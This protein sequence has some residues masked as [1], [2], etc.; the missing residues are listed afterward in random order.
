MKMKKIIWSAVAFFLLT[1][2]VNAQTIEDALRFT[3]S[4]G[5]ISPRA[6]GLGV[7]FHGI[8]DDVAALAYNPAGLS[9]IGKT[10]LSF[11]FGFT[12]FST[13]TNFL[14]QTTP[15]NSNDEYITHFGFAVPFD[16]KQGNGAVGLAYFLENNF[17]NN[18]KY[19]A[20]NPF[21][22][23]TNYY[24]VFGTRIRENNLAYEL[25]LTDTNLNSPITDSLQQKAFLQESGGLHNIVGGV[26][27][28]LSEYVSLGVALQGKWGTYN[29]KRNYSERDIYN[30]YNYFDDVYWTNIDFNRLEVDERIEQK[31]TGISGSIGIQARFED[32]LRF[33]A[34]IRFPTFYEVED[35]SDIYA[36]SYFD[37]GDHYLFE[38][39]YQSSYKL[40]TPFV[41]SAGVSFHALDLTFAFGVEYKDV[42]QLK[43]SDAIR[44]IENLNTTI[45]QELVGQTTWGFGIEYEIPYAPILA[46]ASFSS[47]TSPYVFDIPGA[48]FQ[49]AS[50]GGGIYVAPNIRLDAIFRW[51]SVSEMRTNYGNSSDPETFSRYTF[52]NNPLDIGLQFT[53]RY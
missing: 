21:S 43:F 44:D 19:E 4:N 34:N 1:T 51:S 13:E 2:L 24:S 42:T 9:L 5:Y 36:Q 22:T 25:F 40:R 26:S 23:M 47:T 37:N 8:C 27:F 33:G 50:L 3:K 39:D 16:T 49:T 18:M 48:S 17:N 32:L 14:N 31:I 29:Y 35:V 20:F 38:K 10:E 52:K 6:A 46:R 15:F 7:S 11:G 45:I 12:N 28:D 41:Y 30:K 53:Y